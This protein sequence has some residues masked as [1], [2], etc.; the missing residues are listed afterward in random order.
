MIW[1]GGDYN[2]QI[3]EKRYATKKLLKKIFGGKDCE[4]MYVL[5]QL[6][7]EI[8]KQRCDIMGLSKAKMFYDFENEELEKIAS[9]FH[10]VYQKE[11]ERQGDKRHKDNYVELSENIKEFDRVLVR[12]VLKALELAFFELEKEFEDEIIPFDDIWERFKQKLAWGGLNYEKT[13]I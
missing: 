5:K 7:K 12:H 2:M 11:A 13:Q 3:K 1:I 8:K 4:T 6:R 9:A 10:T